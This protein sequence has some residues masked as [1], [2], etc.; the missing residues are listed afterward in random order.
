MRKRRKIPVQKS[1]T[2]LPAISQTRNPLRLLFTPYLGCGRRT[3]P[4]TGLRSSR[5]GTDSSRT[6][7][8]HWYLIGRCRLRCG[9]DSHVCA[10]DLRDANGDSRR[11]RPSVR[12]AVTERLGCEVVHSSLVFTRSQSFSPFAAI[13]ETESR[14]ILLLQ[15][16]AQLESRVKKRGATPLLN[17]LISG[18]QPKIV[19]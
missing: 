1:S 4:I 15:R 8:S 19:A 17:L 12:Q 3:R 7:C 5:S 9:M 2:H 18:W 10:A 6:P 13:S 16:L 14:I 11:T